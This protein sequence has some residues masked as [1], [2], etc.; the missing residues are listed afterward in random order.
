MESRN[1]HQAIV[2]TDRTDYLSPPSN[3]LSYILAAE[4]LFGIA[5]ELPARANVVR[6][7]MCELAR[8][9]SHLIWL[10]THAL[11]LG[12]T[13][14]FM[15]CWREREQ[16]LSIFELASGVR[17]MTSYFRIGGLAADVPA[18]FAGAC[19]AF[20]RE[21][22]RRIDDYEALLSKNPIF[23]DRTRGV[24]IMSRED[25]LTYGFS[26]P[27]LRASGVPLDIRVTYPYCDYDQ[28]DFDVPFSNE[29]D[30]YA[31]YMCRVREMRESVRLVQ[32]GV[33]KLRELDGAPV[34]V[35]NPKIIFPKREMIHRSMESLIHHF[36]LVSE[37]PVPPA[38]EAYACVESPRGELGTYVFSDGSNKPHRVRFRGPGFFNLQALP[39]IIKQ[40]L[41][42]DVVA[43]IGSIDIVLGEIDR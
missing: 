8:I 15:Y 13:T 25:A 3:N 12:A 39:Q 14:V 10:G 18:E 40:G 31:R 24:G 35:D 42:A 32:Q 37:G 9:G 29:C 16:I 2:L 38:G 1:Y 17:M 19:E 27:C 41:V 5:T 43:C 30:V 6:V 7:I 36:K 11:D 26:G 34:K 22:P 23:V 20:C 4:K 28:Y 33:R 21:M